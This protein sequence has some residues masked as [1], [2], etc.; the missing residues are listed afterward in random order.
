M[1]EA[2]YFP[3]LLEFAIQRRL[4]TYYIKTNYK[5]E[6][7]ENEESVSEGVSL[8][9]RIEFAC[10]PCE[11]QVSSRSFGYIMKPK[12]LQLGIYLCLLRLCEVNDI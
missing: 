2:I 6:S 10:F 8:L 5:N 4:V 3:R 12:D 7:S 1:R 9:P 11:T